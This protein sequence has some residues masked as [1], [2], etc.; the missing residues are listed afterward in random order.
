MSSS[1]LSW[2]GWVVT[3]E[4]GR[5]MMRLTDGGPRL[6]YRQVNAFAWARECEAEWNR[7]HNVVRVYLTTDVSAVH[8]NEVQQ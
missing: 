4:R 1:P 5:M 6:F 8:A 2:D 3:D 7:P